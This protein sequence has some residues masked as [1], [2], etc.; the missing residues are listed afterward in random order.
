MI[1]HFYLLAYS[2]YIITTLLISSI[3]HK[4]I[5]HRK[6]SFLSH[7]MCIYQ[8]EFITQL[9][10]NNLG[11]FHFLHRYINNII[12]IIKKYMSNQIPLTQMNG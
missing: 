10:H 8:N 9:I 1:I 3:K 6:I 4:K 12:K 7:I 5:H 11:T 2:Y